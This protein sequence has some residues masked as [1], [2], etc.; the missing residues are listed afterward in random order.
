[1][2]ELFFIALYYICVSLVLVVHVCVCVCVCVCVWFIKAKPSTHRGIRNVPC[3]KISHFD[4]C[5]GKEWDRILHKW[6]AKYVK[7][8][9][10]QSRTIYSIISS[11]Y[12]EIVSVRRSPRSARP[13][14]CFPSYLPRSI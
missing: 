13:L 2:L 12:D 5:F 6:E 11:N 4:V 7:Y 9:N 3:G 1:M 14:P 10:A 8:V